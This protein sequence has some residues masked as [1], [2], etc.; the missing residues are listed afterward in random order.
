MHLAGKYGIEDESLDFAGTV[1]LDAKISE[2]MTGYKRLLLKLADPLFKRKGGGSAIPIKITG[3]R[4]DPSF[5]LD[6][7]RL[8]KK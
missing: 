5:G 6:A 7:G 8:F 2:T 3:T 4:K 1:Y